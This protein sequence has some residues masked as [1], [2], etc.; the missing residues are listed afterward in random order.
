[1]AVVAGAAKLACDAARLSGLGA[2][3]LL[4]SFAVA[5]NGSPAPA[6]ILP[7]TALAALGATVAWVLAVSG[8][9]VHPDRPQ[10]LAVARRSASSRSCWRQPARGT[11]AGSSGTGR[12]LLFCR[13]IR[14]SVLCLRQPPSG[15]AGAERAC[16]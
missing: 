3:L 7:Q 10:R 13:P 15:A 16:V 2:V 11:E 12:Q 9:F 5:A 14:H 6:D 1:M 8:W 4:F